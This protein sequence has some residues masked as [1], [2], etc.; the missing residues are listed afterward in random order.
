MSA[1]KAH[2]EADRAKRPRLGL[3]GSNPDPFS[4]YRSCI[5]QLRSIKCVEYNIRS[6]KPV[7]AWAL[8]NTHA[9]MYLHSLIHVCVCVWVGVRR[10]DKFMRRTPL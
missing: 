7:F 3:G 6:F 4:L 5:S 8:Q 1:E 10:L 9:V 2:Q